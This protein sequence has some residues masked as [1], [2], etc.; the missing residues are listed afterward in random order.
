[1]NKKLC[2]ITFLVAF[3]ISLFSYQ[4]TQAK[5]IKVEQATSMY[6]TGR[7]VYYVSGRNELPTGV[8]RLDTKTG[9]KKEIFSHRL[10]GNETA[11]FS[12]V[13]VKGKY[14]YVV[15]D[16]IYGTGASLEYVYRI[17]KDGK[18]AKCLGPGTSINIR[19]N[20]IYYRRCKVETYDD[21]KMTMLADQASMK[22]DGSDKRSEKGNTFRPIEKSP[23]LIGEGGLEKNKKTAS[24]GN[25]IYMIENQGKYLTH[26]DMKKGKQKQIY[27][28]KAGWIVQGAYI[29]KN[30]IFVIIRDS[31]CQNFRRIYMNTNGKK[32]KTMSKWYPWG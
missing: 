16:H 14:L 32:E 11:G 15:W 2:G 4:E 24:L 28:A 19:G 17:S 9:K 20:R 26:L 6:S 27:K 18:Q 3:L 1:M 22:L 29:H 25:H 10:R 31:A 30:A 12:Q 7:Y 21:I 13:I 5:T 23:C 8:M